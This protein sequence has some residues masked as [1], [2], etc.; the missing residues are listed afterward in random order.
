MNDEERT[1]VF[2]VYLAGLALLKSGKS[3]LKNKQNFEKG[4]ALIPKVVN[5]LINDAKVL[6]EK[7]N[8]PVVELINVKTED[9]KG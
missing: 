4:H 3:N 7:Q 6:T 8:N 1:L 2:N 9:Q 5:M